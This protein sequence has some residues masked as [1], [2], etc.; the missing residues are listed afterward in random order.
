MLTV[1]AVA[2]EREPREAS[3][4]ENAGMPWHMMTRPLKVGGV[5]TVG[6]LRRPA[7][8]IRPCTTAISTSGSR[9][10]CRGAG[11]D[12]RNITSEARSVALQLAGQLL[13]EA[14]LGLMD[15]TRAAPIFAIAS[16]SP[17]PPTRAPT[18]P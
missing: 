10:F 4:R 18:R 2:P 1:R 17:R 16:A 5:P 11:V 6:S 3:K 7:R 15:S 9:A 12:P 14:V 8:K 13:R